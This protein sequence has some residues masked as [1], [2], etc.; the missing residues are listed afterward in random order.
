MRISLTP[1][2]GAM[3][4]AGLSGLASG[5][6]TNGDTERSFL[7]RQEHVT[8]AD[9]PPVLSKGN[10]Q[11]A[12]DVLPVELVEK[13]KSGEFEIRTQATTDLPLTPAYVEATR[14]NA[15]K[16]QLRKDGSLT[17]YV[18]GRPFPRID[19]ADPQAGLKLA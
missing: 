8:P 6:D 2:V 5:V 17:G 3:L 15:G 4:A 1:I 13:L 7:P 18:G 10:W 11:R 16:A 12:V 19:A 9:L 14:R